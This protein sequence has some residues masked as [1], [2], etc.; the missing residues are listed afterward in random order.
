MHINMHRVLGEE[1]WS[2]FI[3]PGTEIGLQLQ[4]HRRGVI[5]REAEAGWRR[6]YV[7]ALGGRVSVS[8]LPAPWCDL[9]GVGGGGAAGGWLWGWGSGLMIRDLGAWS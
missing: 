6:D 4:T 5:M 8:R 3:V 2:W 9:G 7:C 1:S